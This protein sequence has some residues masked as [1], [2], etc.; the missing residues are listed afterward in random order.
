MKIIDILYVFFSKIYIK[1]YGQKNDLWLIIPSH[2]LS[3][4]ITLNLFTLSFF[5]IDINVIYI[6]ALY[7]ILYFVFA[8]ILD[9]RFDYNSVK[10]Y[11]L[12][13]SKIYSII[14]FL[15]ADGVLLSYLMQLS[16]LRNN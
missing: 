6:I 11:D 1:F 8:F 5:F 14:L 3:F 16:R 13:K 4:I 10:N 9:R 2:I 15:I 7:L 12:S